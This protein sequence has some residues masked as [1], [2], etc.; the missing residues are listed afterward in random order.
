MA[1]KSGWQKTQQTDTGGD[2][3]ESLGDEKAMKYDVQRGEQSEDESG[4]TD[5]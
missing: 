4:R 1:V 2:G 5:R 3:K